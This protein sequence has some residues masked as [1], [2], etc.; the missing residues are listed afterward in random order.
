M[1]ARPGSAALADI[2]REWASNP[3]LRLGAVAIAVIVA[4]YL[5]LVLRDWN[6]SLQRSYADRTAYLAK[7]QALAGQDAWIARAASA[8]EVRA[9]LEAEIPEVATIGLAQ[10]T[11]Q[12]WVREAAV[13]FGEGLQVRAAA[14]VPVAADSDVWRV[15]VTVS[16][17]LDP[18][19]YVQLLA[20]VERRPTLAVIEEATVLNRENRTFELT[21]VSYYRV[22]NNGEA[23]ADGAG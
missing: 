18:G 7:M 13:A 6:A 17:K 19:R 5:S 12:G 20:Q 16:G 3:R 1:S 8:A 23:V 21:V 15:P 2:R 11:V 22:R 10:A 14:P 9:A 4:V